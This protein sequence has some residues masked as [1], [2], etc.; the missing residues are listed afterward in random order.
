MKY[1][2]QSWFLIS[3]VSILG[4]MNMHLSILKLWAGLGYVTN[5]KEKSMEILQF[6]AKIIFITNPWIKIQ[7]PQFPKTIPPNSIFL[8]NHL[9]FLDMFIFF[10]H[11]P[12]RHLKTI[13]FISSNRALSTPLIS[14]P[15]RMVESFFVHFTKNGVDREKQSKVNRDMFEYL[16]NGGNLFVCPEGKITN[17]NPSEL[18][19]FKPGFFKIAENFECTFY[20]SIVHGQQESWHHSSAIGGLPANIVWNFRKH[21]GP[22]DLD[23]IKSAM[24]S[25]LDSVVEN[26]Q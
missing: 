1:F 19:E 18:M 9:S 15:S 7:L 13:R 6:W 10:A 5:K 16:D 2:Y 8:S 26:S 14:L 23:S 11:I 25:M 17:E 22:N 12:L 20:L 24:Q 4:F 21:E 3:L